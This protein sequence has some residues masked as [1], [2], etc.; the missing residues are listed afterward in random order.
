VRG[1]QTPPAAIEPEDLERLQHRLDEPEMSDS[2]RGVTVAGRRAGSGIEDSLLR[3]APEPRRQGV[4][5]IRSLEPASRGTACFR[6]L[7]ARQTLSMPRNP[8]AA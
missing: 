4:R 7:G 6:K 5:E 2:V 8:L 3:I 1:D